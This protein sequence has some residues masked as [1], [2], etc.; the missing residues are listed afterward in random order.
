MTETIFLILLIMYVYPFD[1]Y[2]KLKRYERFTERTKGEIYIVAYRDKRYRRSHDM[3]KIR[4]IIDGREYNNEPV[5]D[6]GNIKDI[7]VGDSVTILYDTDDYNKILEE[8]KYED[9][10]RAA[11]RNYDFALKKILPTAIILTVLLIIYL[12]YTF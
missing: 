8:S 6:T 12:R 1:C 7:K 2:L 10:K 9:G 11:E 3:H 5:Y 4:Y